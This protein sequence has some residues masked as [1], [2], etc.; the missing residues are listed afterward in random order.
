MERG[1]QGAAR[2]AQLTHMETAQFY[3]FCREFREKGTLDYLAIQGAANPVLEFETQPAH[4]SK[5]LTETIRLA[6]EILRLSD[7]P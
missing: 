4:S 6:I 2:S 3:F 7:G 5:V 1:F